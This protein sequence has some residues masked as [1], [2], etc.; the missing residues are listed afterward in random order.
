MKLIFIPLSLSATLLLLLTLACSDAQPPAPT[1]AQQG[2]TKQQVRTSVNG[3]GPTAISSVVQKTSKENSAQTAIHTNPNATTPPPAVA[4]ATATPVQGGVQ[5]KEDT[6]VI[7]QD[8]APVAPIA[9]I[10]DLCDW[11]T[12]FEVQGGFIYLSANTS[13]QTQRLE[14][15]AIE[16]TPGIKGFPHPIFNETSGFALHEYSRQE[17]DNS[18]SEHKVAIPNAKTPYSLSRHDMYQPE[19][20]F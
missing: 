11:T 10:L 18:P 8:S 6:S 16:I 19:V 20:S 1:T 17:L 5:P 14:N 4:I 12:S 7:T 9:G 13:P 3:S 2:E 15:L